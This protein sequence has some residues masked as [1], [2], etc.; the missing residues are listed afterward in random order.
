M[1]FVVSLISGMLGVAAIWFA[2]GFKCTKHHVKPLIHAEARDQAR[3]TLLKAACQL[4]ERVPSSILSRAFVHAALDEVALR[5]QKH[6]MDIGAGARAAGLLLIGMAAAALSGGIVAMSPLGLLVGGAVPFLVLSTL[7][8]RRI[9]GHKNDLAHAMPEA[10][11]ALAISLGSGHSLEQALRFVGN[12]ASE[13]IHTEFTRASF[14]MT[15]GIPAAIALDDLLRRLPAP[16]LDLVALALKVSQRTGAPLRDL[17]TQAA[18]MVGERVEL[19]RTLETKTTQARM[20]ARLVTV[21]PV[22][23][24]AIL[25][26]LSGDFRTGL[27]TPIGAG[28]VTVALGLNA[29]AWVLIRRIMEVDVQ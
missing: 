16:G 17:L 8:T 3:L 15:C 28:A 23:M 22:A 7:G 29:V 24:V 1:A 18:D 13:P 14:E 5:A 25:S 6:G 20:S 21:M 19:E 10:F 11:H 26:L 4:G 9:R 12:H 2:T 27:A